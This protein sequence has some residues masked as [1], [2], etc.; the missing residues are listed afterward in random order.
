MMP[1]GTVVVCDWFHA[2]GKPWDS[3]EM[4]LLGLACPFPEGN[5]FF[6]FKVPE[7]G[8]ATTMLVMVREKL[9]ILPVHM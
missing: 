5:P 4:F 8:Q 2:Q 7:A 6:I 9:I 3:V 1:G